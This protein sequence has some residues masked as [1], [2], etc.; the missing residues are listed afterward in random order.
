MAGLPG[1]SPPRV[2]TR[3]TPGPI[4]KKKKTKLTIS[5]T[6]SPSSSSLAACGAATTL[7]QMNN[8]LPRFLEGDIRAFFTESPPL[9]I[10]EDDYIQPLLNEQAVAYVLPT[11]VLHTFPLTH[12][13]R[14]YF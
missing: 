1:E 10:P 6:H 13:F 5:R 14:R 12:A 8:I 9:I 11:T 4:K 2:S 3:P 7:I